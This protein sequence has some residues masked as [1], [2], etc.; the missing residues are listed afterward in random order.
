MSERIVNELNEI[1]TANGRT[2]RAE[3]KDGHIYF[4]GYTVVG[5]WQWWCEITPASW[6]CTDPKDPDGTACFDHPCMGHEK[7]SGSIN[8]WA[9]FVLHT[10]CDKED[11][12][13]TCDYRSEGAWDIPNTA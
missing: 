13:W 6:V 8:V 3:I 11:V 12:D 10:L 5:D 9:N 2:E 4:D 1:L 7:W